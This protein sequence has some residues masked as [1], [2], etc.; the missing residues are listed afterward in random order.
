MSVASGHGY[1]FVEVCYYCIICHRLIQY[2]IPDIR[3]YYGYDATGT[4]Q[5]AF[6]A[7]PIPK[8]IGHCVAARITV[9]QR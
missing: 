1:S 7:V 6:D 8:P 2:R 4:D 9:C 5:I 3:R